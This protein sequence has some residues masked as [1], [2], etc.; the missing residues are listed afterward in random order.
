MCIPI[1][2]SLP[3][4]KTFHDPL[5]LGTLPQQIQCGNTGTSEHPY[6]G[7]PQTIYPLPATNIPL[8][9]WQQSTSLP[10]NSL[11]PH[12]QFQEW[13]ESALLESLPRTSTSSG[14]PKAATTSNRHEF[15]DESELQVT[16]LPPG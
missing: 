16:T 1:I 4:S 9:N 13:T 15:V 12:P 11:G 8:N 7:Q 3:H 6:V 5:D 14:P 2:L 10:Q